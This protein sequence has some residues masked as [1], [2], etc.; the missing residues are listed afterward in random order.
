MKKHFILAIFL[1]LL[2]SICIPVTGSARAAVTLIYFL[3]EP[4]DPTDSI[5]LE[6][7][8]AT[9]LN[10][11][12]FYI[13]RSTSENGTYTRITGFI[14]AEGDGVTGSVYFYFDLSVQNAVRYWYKLEAIDTNN[15]TE[16]HGPVSAQ[17]GGPTPTNTATGPTRTPTLT[18]TSTRTATLPPGV[19]PSITPSP[20][21]TPIVS[22][23]ATNTGGGAQATATQQP[24]NTPLVPDTT[25]TN[26]PGTTA[27]DIPTPTATLDV[28]PIELMFPA[29]TQ[30]AVIQKVVTVV[31]VT[32]IAP[33][34]IILEQSPMAVRGQLGLMFGVVIVLWLVLASF[35]VIYIRR[36]NP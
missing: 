4:D 24:S 1:V 8:T 14:P 22:P 27:T 15:N 3:V 25:P 26:L 32:E 13:V 10:N 33:G 19:T 9:E 28:A 5:Y 31:V 17:L 36:L 34:A 11:A 30:M 18:P 6:W 16:Y 29:P 12:G 20:T 2:V 21:L 23:T 7:E 35:I